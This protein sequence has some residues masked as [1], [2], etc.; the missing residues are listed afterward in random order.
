[1][2]LIKRTL[3]SASLLLSTAV[4][5]APVVIPNSPTVAAGAYVLM[6]YQTGQILAQ[7]NA[8]EQR[9]PASLTKMMTS[10]VLGQELKAGRVGL[11]D[12]IVVSENAWAQ[13]P[14]LEG[15]SLM[16]LKAGSTVKLAD[17]YKGMVIQSGNDA[18]VA[19][20]EH[21]AGTESGYADLMNTWA[22]ELG[23][24]ATIYENAHGLD[25]PSQLTSAYDMALLGR[26]LIRDIPEHYPLYSQKEFTYNKIRQHNRNGLLWDRSLAVDGIKTGHTNNAGYSL[27][28]SAK[29]DNMRLISVVMGAK[30]AKG[31]E[32]ESK[33]LL[34]YGFR[35]FETV[36]PYKAGDTFVSQQIW[37]GDKPE[38]KLGVLE[39]TP[40]T[41]YRGQAANMK[42]EFELS[43]ELQ[44]PLSRGQEV[45]KLY[46]RIDGKDVASYPLTVL[47]DVEEGSLFSKLLDYFKL[48][49]KSLLD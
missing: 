8:H 9:A 18:C 15:S 42:A 45:G 47:E 36:T 48:L 39:D 5:A 43:Q 46:F 22:K 16:W 38:V 2:T 11:E 12:E 6:D 14:K 23:M 20:A 30:S 4:A 29:R 32:A 3:L 34:N 7:E 44:A 10:Y 13:N 1:M 19:I 49:F 41:I 24:T 37:Y 26:A 21:V 35:F 25:A 31:R 33:K 27:V 17:L 40:V 28:A